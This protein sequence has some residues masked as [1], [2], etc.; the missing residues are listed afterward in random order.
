MNKPMRKVSAALAVMF[1]ALFV[2][3]NWIQVVKGGDYRDHPYNQRVLLNE[4]AS[5]RGAIIVDGE[6][7]ASSKKTSGELKYQRVYPATTASPF[8][9]VTGYYSFLFGTTGVE[10]AENDILSGDSS[11]LF[12]TKLTNLLTGRNPRGG[13]VE[14]TIDMKTQL[15]A[16]NAMKGAHGMRRG[17]VV[18][19]DPST[20]RI[21]ALV[22]TPSFDPNPLASHD[23]DVVSKYWNRY[24]N[25]KRN[26]M[27]N[28]ALSERYFPGSVFKVIDT[29]AA[30]KM[31]YTPDKRIA[32]PNSYWPLE[33]AAKKNQKNICPAGLNAPCV[34]NFEGEQCDN[35]K[36]ATLE[37]ALVRSCNTAFA[38]LA[39]EK[40]GAKRLEQQAAAFGIGMND[41]SVPLP[42]AASTIGDPAELERDKAALAQTAFGQRSAQIT[43]LQAAM[44]S[45]AV[46]NNGILMKPYLVD[47]ELRPNLSAL[48]TYKP[49]QLSQATDPDVASQ[50]V[51]MMESVV[52]KGTGQPAAITDPRLVKAGV[53]VGGKTGTADVG[54]TSASKIPPDA[55]FS[56]FA[57]VKGEP[58]IAVAVIIQNGGVA[59]NETT[60]GQA[61]G[62]VAKSVMT[63]YL[64]SRV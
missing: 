23:S 48:K 15:A 43:P 19:I 54:A 25:D 55:W 35:G 34:Q 18:A 26:P 51:T 49:E 22:S 3:L 24:R 60:G 30:L 11:E 40:L 32:A 44:I 12:T 2:N 13:N 16:Y 29:A 14:L 57:M 53:V 63:A 52:A 10:D 1:L 50:L 46:A 58:K 21:L 38:E 36:D 20:G 41:L 7:V 27:D 28:R 33:V 64:K 59:G 4:Y 45:A 37:T 17:A 5:P 8:A 47:K 9:P 56:G 61:A 62:P 6:N 42:V 31:G 39:V